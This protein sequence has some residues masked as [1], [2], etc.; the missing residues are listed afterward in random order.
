MK[1]G[2]Y[3]III[4]EEYKPKRVFKPQKNILSKKYEIICHDKR[5]KFQKNILNFILTNPKRHDIVIMYKYRN[6]IHIL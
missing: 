4:T 2:F 5:V 3:S 1:Y 6:D